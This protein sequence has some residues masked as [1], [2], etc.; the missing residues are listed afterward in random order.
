MSVKVTVPFGDGVITTKDTVIGT[1]I[2]EE[3]FT[4]QSSHIAMSLDG[5]E[6]ITNGSGSH[7]NLRKLHTR[8]DLLKSTTCKCGG[9][10]VYSNLIGCDGGRLVFD[11]CCLVSVNGDIVAQGP[12]F[13][14]DEVNVTIATVDLDDVTSYR[15][16]VGS[17]GPQVE[18]GGTY[19]RFHIPV[20]VCCSTLPLSQAIE[21][22]Y[23]MPEEEIMLGQL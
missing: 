3:L 17:R 22:H 8:I 6:V 7:F 4:G 20:S 15:S 16:N 2:C 10:Y 9:V 12:Q 5:V 1:E 13:T 21:V 23:Y 11:G 18:R 19:P 14:L